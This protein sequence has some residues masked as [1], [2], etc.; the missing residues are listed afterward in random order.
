MDSKPMPNLG[1][2]HVQARTGRMLTYWCAYALSDE[3]SLSYVAVVNEGLA[4]LGQHED[5]LHYD[6]GGVPAA[7]LVRTR[8][9]QYLDRTRFDEGKLPDRRWVGWYGPCL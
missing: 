9:L 8:L 1:G 6:P 7:A 4:L 3:T 2:K 5:S